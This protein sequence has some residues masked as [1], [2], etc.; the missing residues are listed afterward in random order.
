MTDDLT[1]DA[2]WEYSQSQQS[3]NQL[4]YGFKWQPGPMQVLNAEYRY[5]SISEVD[6]TGMKQIDVSAQWP[7]APRW[8]GVARTNYSIQDK[9]VL[10]GLV[11]VEYKQDCW[12]FRFVAQR[13]VVTSTVANVPSSATTSL[14]FQL[15]LNGLSKLGSNPLETLRRSI[16]GYQ[17]INQP[18][19][20]RNY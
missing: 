4:T 2:V 6:T 15:E 13:Y 10:D 20:Q 16:L 8:Y 18:Q 5:K 9:R 17:P 7:L 14:F 3:T 19:T 11:G 1:L 12:I